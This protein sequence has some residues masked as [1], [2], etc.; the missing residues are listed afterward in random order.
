[1]LPP[2]SRHAICMAEPRI[3]AS[4]KTEIS[5]DKRKLLKLCHDVLDDRKA[6]Q[7][8][9]LDVREQS[10]ITDFFV[11]ATATSQPH[12]R[13]MRGELDKTLKA[14]KIQLIGVDAE[15]GSGWMVIDA[16]DVMVHLF[17]GETRDFYRLE[18]LWKDARRV[19]PEDLKPVR[20]KRA[21]PAKKASVKKTAPKKAVKKA[22][23][24]KKVVKKAPVKKAARKAPAKKSAAKKTAAKAAK[25][26]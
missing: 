5:P 3:M 1:M 12:L 14:E 16:F 15:V 25:K 17:T 2:R 20:K 24:K 6:E 19:D 13:A 10:S 23:P 4:T 11:I 8:I 18:H 22:A 9:L 7:L 26:I 21:T